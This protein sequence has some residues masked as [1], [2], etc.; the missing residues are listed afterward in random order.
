MLRWRFYPFA[1]YDR[2]VKLKPVEIEALRFPR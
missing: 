1:H 2:G